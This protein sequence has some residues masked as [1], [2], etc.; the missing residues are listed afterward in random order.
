M[1]TPPGTSLG[2]AGRYLTMTPH[3]TFLADPTYES[4]PNAIIAMA[5]FDVRTYDPALYDRLDVMRHDRFD[6]AVPKR[7]ADFLAGRLVARAA[8]AQFGVGP[9]DIAI[10]PNR[11]PVWP[12]GF[13]GSITHTNDSGA[14]I[15]TQSDMICGIDRE[16]IARGSALE[17]LLSRCL[18][19]SERLWMETQTRHP[20][21]VMATLAFGAKECIY[22]AL[23]PT[24]QR[25][26]GF[27]CA[28]ILGWSDDGRLAL[29]LTEALHSTF[30]AG[31]VFDVRCDLDGDVAQ[32]I[33]LAPRPL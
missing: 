16:A 33:L 4:L 7:Q 24:V 14:A 11:A 10:G 17:A 26:F 13:N 15:V 22:K 27:E 28:E 2:A 32:T 31:T 21:D 30:P 19:S 8:L 20:F 1:A 29:R 12:N 9:A 23:A 6:Q 3:A 5:K 25:F 18:S